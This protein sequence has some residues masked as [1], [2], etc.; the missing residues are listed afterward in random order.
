MSTTPTAPDNTYGPTVFVYSAEEGDDI[1]RDHFVRLKTGDH[2][3]RPLTEE[4]QE[5]G[6]QRKG[7]LEHDSFLLLMKQG[8]GKAERVHRLV[9]EIVGRVVTIRQESVQ[10]GQKDHFC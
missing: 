3:Q 5:D 10:L 4:E 2:K 7:N 6:R 1:E 9:Y 8:P